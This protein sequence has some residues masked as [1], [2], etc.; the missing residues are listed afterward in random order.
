[1]LRKEGRLFRKL[2]SMV[3]RDQHLSFGL[4]RKVK[5]SLVSW[6]KVSVVEGYS[7][8]GS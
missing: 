7:V 5:I 2:A 6:R 8:F 1:M 4:L 3:D